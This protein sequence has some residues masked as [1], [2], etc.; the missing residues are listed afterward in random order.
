MGGFQLSDR[1]PSLAHEPFACP[2][3]QSCI[4]VVCWF[5]E[6]PS[7]Q[8][9]KTNACCTVVRK[10]RLFGSEE[11]ASVD[12]DLWLAVSARYFVHLGRQSERCMH[13]VFNISII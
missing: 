2:Q 13:F 7:Q 6:L 4:K 10:Q 8:D 3:T 11:P 9:P 5:Q 12:R 1:G